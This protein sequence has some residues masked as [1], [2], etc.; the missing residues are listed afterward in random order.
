MRILVVADG[1]NRPQFLRSGDA[2]TASIRDC[3]FVTWGHLLISQLAIISD[4]RSPIRNIS[5]TLIVT[6]LVWP[7]RSENPPGRPRARRISP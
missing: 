2:A 6:H 4:G 1:A 3:L 7:H 5:L